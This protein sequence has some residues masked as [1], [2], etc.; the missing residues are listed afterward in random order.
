MKIIAFSLDL[1]GAPIF[2]HWMKE[3][4]TVIVAQIQDIKDLKNDDGEEHPE[5]KKKRLSNYDGVF[6]KYDAK[7]VLKKMK[8]IKDK[9]EWFVFF[10][11]NNLWRYADAAQKMG[12]KNGFF[13]TQEDHL[14]EKDRKAAKDVVLKYYKELKLTE[15]T[16]Y[17][18]IEDGKKYVEE[19]P[20]KVFVIKGNSDDAETFCT[21]AEGALAGME[22]LNKMESGKK[23]YEAQG[24]ILEEKIKDPI[25]ITPEIIFYN[26]EVVATNIDIENKPIG[27]GS[28]GVQTGCASCILV[29]T[30]LEEKINKIAFP[31]YVFDMAK[32][33]KG[34]FV[35][36]ASILIDPKDGTMYFGEFCSNRLGWDSVFAEIAMS[37]GATLWIKKIMN[38]QNPFKYKY[39]ATVRGFNMPKKSDGLSYE[40][41]VKE[42]EWLES[43]DDKLFLYEMKFK[44]EKG[45]LKT[46]N[47]GQ[48]MDV[49]VSASAADNIPQTVNSAYKGIRGFSFENI[50]YRPKEDFN[51]LDYKTS[52]LNR[53]NYGK[54]QKL[55]EASST[56]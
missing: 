4:N 17:K 18:T 41:P 15:T 39:G 5:I 52:V 29:K 12:F 38:G 32:K 31:K 47:T 16:E 27:A 34:M 10:D 49:V 43:E 6:E 50:I 13:P 24:Y 40:L 3:G 22:L 46:Y 19:N 44:E 53:Y 35:W 2:Y 25:E 11:F 8:N 56:N 7:K 1:I 33:R 55:Y 45:E 51:S 21:S 20:D 37:G 23:D 54:E 26:G 48:S 28:I 9:D 36:D 42:M 14:F 30:E